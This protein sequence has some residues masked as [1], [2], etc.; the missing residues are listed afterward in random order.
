MASLKW[1]GIAAGLAAV[2]PTFANEAISS[3]QLTCLLE[4]NTTVNLAS[5]TP[6]IIKTMRVER[7]D[8][9]E[10]DQVL[11]R[12]RDD[13]ERASVALG[14]ARV[15]FG[16]RK[17]K[18]NSDLFAKAL[19]SAHER[20]EIET[21]IQ[22]AQLELAEARVRLRAREIRSTIN[23]VIVERHGSPGDYVGEDPILTLMSL[24]PLYVEVIAPVELFG[25]IVKDM[26][27][28][29]VPDVVGGSHSATVSIVD[30]IVD[31]AS[32][33]F[34]VRLELPNPDNRL[35]AGLKCE[36]RFSL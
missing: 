1:L 4:P 28:E 33:T 3:D 35:P 31:P 5:D 12:L 27:A 7:G 24:N 20:D 16:K 11:V 21:E 17:A 32:N 22:L 26:K 34:R 9:V 14:R 18:R 23:G 25:R 30:P 15:A 19:V 36:V 29:V 6:G 8:S 13:A 10:K 2:A